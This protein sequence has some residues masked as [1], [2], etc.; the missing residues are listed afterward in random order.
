MNKAFVFGK[1]L[2]FHKGHEAMIKFALTKCDFLSVLICC[3]SNENYNSKVR[4]LWIEKSFVEVKNI[5]III[6]DYNE[7]ELPNT[8]QSSEE[9]SKIWSLI[10]KN[11]FPSHNL[12]ITSEPYGDFVAKFMSIKHIV[13]DYQRVNFPISST[14]IKNDFFQ[15]WNFLPES[16]KQDLVIKVVLLGT[17]STGKTMISEKLA[18]HFNCGL[19][20]ETARDIVINS[21]NFTY[22]DLMLI[23]KKHSENIRI[24]ISKYSMLIIDTDIHITSS[25][26][27]H[28]F[29]RKLEIENEIY[30]LNKANLYLYLTKEISYYQDG[31]RLNENERN[32]LDISHRR[33]LK[34]FNINFFEIS[35]NWDKRFEQ[36]KKMTTE[37]IEKQINT[38]NMYHANHQIF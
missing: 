8:S 31:T 4:K 1:F 19:V 20:Y 22:D 6:Y 29:N 36:A 13:F 16:V 26:S 7:D 11:I 24:A 38:A 37:L 3:S 32:L 34:N 14:L 17:E 23:A 9:V 2:P 15:H 28:F 21:N 35:G 10:F 5:E 18:T 33:T 30:H 25:Y 27:E 12:L